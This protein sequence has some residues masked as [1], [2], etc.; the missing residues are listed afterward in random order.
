[1]KCNWYL[2]GLV[3]LAN[4]V[5]AANAH[6]AFYKWVD[7]NGETHYTQTPP[8]ESQLQKNNLAQTTSATPDEQKTINGLIGNWVG[9]REKD[10]VVLEFHKDGRFV[11]RSSVAKGYIQNGTGQWSVT[12]QMIKWE[13]SR[14]NARWRYV[15]KGTKH[16]SVIEE[17]SKN[18]LVLREPNGDLTKLTRVKDD[19]AE[20]SIC[21]QPLQD[22]VTNDKLWIRLIDNHC[23][24]RVTALLG[25]KK[26]S[27]KDVVNNES[28]LLYAIE[29]DKKPLVVLLIKSGADINIARSSDGIT[30][31]ILAAQLGNFQVVNI[32]ISKGARL[33]AADSNKSTA[34]IVA[35]KENHENIVKQLLSVGADLN[36]MDNVGLTA[37]K[38]AEKLGHRNVVQVINDYKR[39]T[40]NK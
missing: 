9:T 11:D 28:P 36:A 40:G 37:L 26:I 39:L 7:K 1:M 25:E 22:G 31:L 13:Y 32:L 8:P 38:H 15:K 14:K 2:I 17:I 18:D 21:D 4:G 27:V 16:F 24:A 6:A 33:N 30:P 12:G 34:L 29:Q 20:V 23:A 5:I 3:I 19:A 35:A 10:Q